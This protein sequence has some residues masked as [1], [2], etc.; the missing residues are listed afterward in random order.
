MTRNDAGSVLASDP[1]LDVVP[2][3]LSPTSCL[4]L[5][6]QSAIKKLKIPLNTKSFITD[7][8]VMSPLLPSTFT[9]SIPIKCL[10]AAVL[11]TLQVASIIFI[12]YTHKK[13]IKLIILNTKYAV[14]IHVVNLTCILPDVGL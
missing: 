7:Q 14:I 11:L 5:Y 13:I 6:S 10:E 8:G 9:T 1:L 2:P 12:A 4:S 3:S